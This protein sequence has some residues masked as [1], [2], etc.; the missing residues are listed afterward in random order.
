MSAISA[1]SASPNAEQSFVTTSIAMRCFA[2]V[3]VANRPH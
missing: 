3:F 1:S 2:P